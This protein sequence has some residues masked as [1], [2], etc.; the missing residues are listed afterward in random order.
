MMAE[1]AAWDKQVLVCLD[2]R[3]RPVSFPTSPD[4]KAEAR[5]LRNAIKEPFIRMCCVEMQM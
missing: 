2:E 5:S 3:K 1:I 4:T